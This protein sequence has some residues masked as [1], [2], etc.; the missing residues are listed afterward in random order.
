MRVILWIAF[1]CLSIVAESKYRFRFHLCR[2][3][4]QS[5]LEQENLPSL[6]QIVFVDDGAILYDDKS[7]LEKVG[8]SIG[9][10]DELENYSMNYT[11][12]GESVHIVVK[13]K[14]SEN[15][16]VINQW[17]HS[18]YFM[19]KNE[20]YTFSG[21]KETIR[22]SLDHFIRVYFVC[23]PGNGR[24]VLILFGE[25]SDRNAN[26]TEKKRTKRDAQPKMSKKSEKRIEMLQ[27]LHLKLSLTFIHFGFAVAAV[28][29]V[30]V[31]VVFFRVCNAAKPMKE[32]KKASVKNSEKANK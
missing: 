9:K 32:A 8:L 2:S 6:R 11:T 26:G 28:V 27:R 22:P 3:E 23:A 24:S 20:K 1:A 14:K 31:L 25:Q 7:G 4:D 21:K 18:Y 5:I 17:T 19:G 13:F 16:L 12:G 30:V 29:N 10:G 15:L